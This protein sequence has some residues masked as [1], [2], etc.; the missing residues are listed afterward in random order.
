MTSNCDVTKSAHQMQMTTICHRMKRP[1]EN[2]QRTPLT[3]PSC[4]PQWNTKSQL[5]LSVRWNPLFFFIVWQII[6]CWAVLGA[7]VEQPFDV[8][9]SAT[10]KSC[11]P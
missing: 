10:V 4:C 6:H 5:Y 1:H 11:T 7:G 3:T 9:L 2:F 8:S